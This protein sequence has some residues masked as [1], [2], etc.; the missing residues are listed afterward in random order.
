MNSLSFQSWRSLRSCIAAVSMICA[1]TPA[2][3]QSE[4]SVDTVAATVNGIE[5]TLGELIAVRQ[6]LPQELSGL[7]DHVLMQALVSQLVD[8]T[9]LAQK[10]REEG[11]DKRKTAEIALKIQTRAVLADSY[12]SERMV[13]DVTEAAVLAAYQRDYVNVTRPNEIRARHIL[14]ESEEKAIMVKALV[15]GG[16]DFI[17]TAKQHGIDPTAPN[18]GL[19]GWLRPGLIGPG[20]DAVAFELDL[21]VISDPV[22][23]AYGWHVLRVEEIRE[24]ASPTL[25]E[26][27][28][29]IVQSLSKEAQD[30]AI[31]DARNAAEIDISEALDPSLIRNDAL[32][33]D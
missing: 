32:L 28:S 29:Q 17:E 11:L 19:I 27:E 10:A 22:R 6:T 5:I 18:G 9:L 16:A 8:Q 24:Q 4:V 33:V 1:T 3:A 21:G 23:T 26:V 30:R 7:P 2:Y 14:V 20:F 15:D 31:T 12:M 25:E 13:A